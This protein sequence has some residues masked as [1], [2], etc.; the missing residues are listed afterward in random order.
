M[1]FYNKYQ[2]LLDM[3]SGKYNVFVL[4]GGR[5]SLKTG[6]ACRALLLDMMKSK[7]RCVVFR[8][9]MSTIEQSLYTEFISL[10]NGEFKAKGF[11][12]DK[13]KIYHANGSE[14]FFSGL[15]DQNQKS[16]EKVK[17]LADVDRLMVDEAQTVSDGVLSVLLKTVRKKGAVMIFVYNR[18]APNLPV[19]Q[20]LFIDY[21]NKKAPP[22]TYFVEV[23]YPEIRHLG[24]LSDFFL[25]RAELIEKNKPDE[26]AR[27]YLNQPKGL[28]LNKVVRYWNKKNICEDLR[29]CD[30]L[31]LHLCMDFNVDPM[32][33]VC[34]HKSKDKLFV[35]DEIVLENT[36]TQDAILEFINRYG[37]H[38]A[39]I[40]LNGDASGDYRKTQSKYTDYAI[41]K[42]TLVKHEF[43][44][45]G[46]IRR[47]N[48]PIANRIKA[49]NNLV[50]GD[51]GKRRLL[52][53]PC[54][55]WLIYNMENL[56][57]K[58][59]TSLLD[60]PSHQMLKNDNEAKF[61]GHIFDAV[62]YA[63]EFYWPVLVK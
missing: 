11:R 26:Y 57:Y 60:L 21:E 18:I 48:P 10:I 52:V 47:F 39:K 4:T 8:E 45:E 55:K 6:H 56:R 51:D 5:G 61:L 62:S 42:N 19:E 33:W 49:F 20:Q 53:H 50:L 9:V 30:D 24:L 22:K 7:K 27:D 3:G 15:S 2:P 14:L 23:N 44:V 12:Y 54:C 16:R 29:Y 63:A 35:F 37:N 46:Q 43:Q 1:I 58:A 34:A 17:G 40:I 41:V 28:N 32:M 36:S 31:N 13:N 25:E 59:G 38:K